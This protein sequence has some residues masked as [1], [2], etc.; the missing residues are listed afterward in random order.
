MI[1]RLLDTREVP[2][3]SLSTALESSGIRP[4][5]RLDDFRVACHLF[6]FASFPDFGDARGLRGRAKEWSAAST[7]GSPPPASRDG[8]MLPMNAI[9]PGARYTTATAA[10]SRPDG[11]SAG[12]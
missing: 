5:H 8:D 6:R 3:P 10:R 9:R 11:P 4:R 2:A 1:C 7:D 12:R